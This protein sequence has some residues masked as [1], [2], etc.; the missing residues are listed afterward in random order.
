MGIY[1]CAQYSGIFVGGVIGGWLYGK[2]NF[3]SVYLF[4]VV[5]ALFWLTLSFFMRQ[6]RYLVTQIVRLNPSQQQRWNVFAE[7][8]ALIPG[9]VEV[10]L[11]SD[12]GL[13]YLKMERQTSKNPDFIR[14]KEQLQLSN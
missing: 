9:I 7:Q 10:T 3:Q 6:P 1:S 8:F 2:Y 14:L 11:V 12:E 4:C 5:L 13:A